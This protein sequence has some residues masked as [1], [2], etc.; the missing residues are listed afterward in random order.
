MCYNLKYVVDLQQLVR[1]KYPKCDCL[2]FFKYNVYIHLLKRE[3]ENWF[4][5][6]NASFLNFEFIISIV[7]YIYFFIFNE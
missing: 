1:N 3:T 6:S 7:S 2:F 5:I 4:C